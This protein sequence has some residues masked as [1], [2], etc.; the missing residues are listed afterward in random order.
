MRTFQIK[1]NGFKDIRKQILIWMIPLLL[2]AAAFGVLISEYNSSN[3][4]VSNTHDLPLI[5][6]VILVVMTFSLIRVIKRQKVIFETYKLI[7]DDVRIIRQQGN[8]PDINLG[9]SEIKSITRTSK[10]GLVI[11]GNS[12]L[13]MILVPAQLDDLPSLEKLLLENCNIQMSVSKPLMQRLLIPFTLFVLGLM[14]VIYI[15]DNK[16]LVLIS[17]IILLP[18]MIAGFIKLQTNKNID[19]KTRRSSYWMILMFL[20]IIGI[21]IKK[22]IG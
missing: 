19:N 10:G 7:I 14:S 12:P 15:S 20:I 4:T 5:I 13:N 17:G 16:I 21:V 3:K 18:I 9:F 8:T 1:E 11:K 2:I 22:M 6:A